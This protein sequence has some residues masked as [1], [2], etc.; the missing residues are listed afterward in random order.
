MTQ[1]QGDFRDPL[2]ILLE[3]ER[4][5]CKG[6]IHRSIAWSVEAC[7][8]P[9]RTGKAAKRCKFYVTKEGN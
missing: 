4:R 5:T 9:R 7:E 6:C 2:I 1:R 3:R 8:H